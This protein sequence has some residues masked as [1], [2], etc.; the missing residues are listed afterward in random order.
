MP[1]Y[2]GRT[3]WIGRCRVSWG[4]STPELLLGA[5]SRVWAL[6]K[7]QCCEAGAKPG[8]PAWD[9][10]WDGTKT[11]LGWGLCG[12]GR[13]LELWVGTAPLGG[14]LP[15]Q[16][17]WDLPCCPSLPKGRGREWDGKGQRRS[18]NLERGGGR[19]KQSPSDGK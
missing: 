15:S 14:I 1:S 17:R 7:G 10:H 3:F 19:E 13:K 16:G 18:V 9:S 4:Q 5:A 6:D 12:T 2:L 11:L 8:P